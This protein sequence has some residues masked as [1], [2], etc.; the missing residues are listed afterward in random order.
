[1]T[2]AHKIG[3]AGAIILGVAL[4]AYL[5]TRSATQDAFRERLDATFTGT[6]SPTAIISTS[7]TMV[8]S[9]LPE[10]VD[11]KAPIIA[12]I[13]AQRI[14]ARTPVLTESVA[15]EAIAQSHAGDMASRGF[16]SH[17]DPDGVTFQQRVDASGYAGTANAEN[18]AL[19][20]HAAVT[21][22]AGWMDSSAHRANLLNDRY[23]AVGV[24][25][26]DGV[27]QGIPVVFVVAVFGDLK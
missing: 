15:L 24:G 1:M 11:R 3:I 5:G 8:P 19:T 21:V 13:N 27:W 16:F 18:L 2:I 6:P 23:V 10:P 14:S 9:R 7:P 26:A 25:I 22:V 20:S 17:T 4:L 12:A